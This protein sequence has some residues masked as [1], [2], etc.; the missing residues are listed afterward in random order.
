MA[1]KSGDAPVNKSGGAIKWIVMAG[2][3]L[4]LGGV[5]T[6]VV[7]R[8]LK[9]TKA[10]A[11]ESLKKEEVKT[12][13]GLEPFLVNLADKDEIRFVKVTFQLGLA[14]EKGNSTTPVFLAQARDSIISLLSSKTSEEILSPVG[15]DKLREEIRTRLN[16]FLHGNKIVDVFIVE[17][18]VQL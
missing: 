18:V 17:F 14:D 5:L 3:A 8:Y 12:T 2:L 1:E 6:F 4:A 9:G 7:L 16:A 10:V 13:L 11:A 15:K